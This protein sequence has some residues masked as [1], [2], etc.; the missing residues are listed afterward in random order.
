MYDASKELAIFYENH[1]RLGT[2][3]RNALGGYRDLNL[4]RLTA[5]LKSLGEK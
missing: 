3:L 1:V 2:Q 5:G 4:D